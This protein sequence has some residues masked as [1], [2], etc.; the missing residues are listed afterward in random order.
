MIG[1]ASGL[2][3]C[4]WLLFLHVSMPVMFSKKL[5]CQ[6]ARRDGPATRLWDFHMGGV[7]LFV[8]TQTHL[9]RR[10]PRYTMSKRYA[11]HTVP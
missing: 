9:R 8:M 11:D 5:S 2:L 7:L 6:K 1:R 10:A 4:D 3:E